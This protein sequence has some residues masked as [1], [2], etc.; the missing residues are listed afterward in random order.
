M[1]YYWLFKLEQAMILMLL[2][3]S[4]EAGRTWRRQALPRSPT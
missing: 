1:N 4:P 3:L 2:L